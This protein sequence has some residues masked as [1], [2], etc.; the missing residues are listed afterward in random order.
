MAEAVAAIPATPGPSS[1]SVPLSRM[2][3]G[4]NAIAETREGSGSSP[5]S[6][7]PTRSLGPRPSSTKGSGRERCASWLRE[8]NPRS[9][10]PNFSAS[11]AWLGVWSFRPRTPAQITRGGGAT[12]QC[13]CSSTEDDPATGTLA[14]ST[15]IACGRWTDSLAAS[16]SSRCGPKMRRRP[17]LG[18]ICPWL[19]QLQEGDRTGPQ[20]V[21]Q[22]GRGDESE[23]SEG[24]R[25]FTNS[26]RSPRSC[27]VS[28]VPGAAVA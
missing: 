24:T 4:R 12:P 8:A 13:R 6:P 19:A 16:D 3:S 22:D 10:N 20:L 18:S 23:R 25:I 15:S 27:W 14:L 11:Q 28:P 1:T 21:R 9:S 26:G 7:R 2:I 17:Q 5:T